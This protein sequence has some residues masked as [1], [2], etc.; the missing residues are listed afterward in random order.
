MNIIN[1]KVNF[2]KGVCQL[3]KGIDLITGDYNSTKMVFDFIDNPT[4]IKVLEM[5]SPDDE[6]TYLG[7][8]QNNEVILVG[9]KEVTTKHENVTY[10]KYVDNNDNV[11]W[12]DP[13]TEKIYDNEWVEQQSVSLDNLTVVTKDVSLFNTE[14]YYI[15]EISLYGDNS[16]LT[17]VSAKIKVKPQQVLEDDEIVT[18]YLPIFDELLNDVSESLNDMDAALDEVDN[19]DFDISKSGVATTVTLTKKDGTTKS[20]QILDATINGETT[21]TIVEGTNI[22][23]TQSGSTMTINNTYDDSEILGNISDLETNKADKSEIPTKTS[24]IT[25]DSGFITKD[26]NNLTNYTTT[27]NMTTAINNAVGTETVNRQSADNN[28]QGQ[29]DAITSASDVVDVV[30][31]YTDLQNYDTSKLTDK[32]LI[33]VMQDSTHNNALSYY[34][35]VS[36]AWS[37][38]G[39]EGPFYT[40]SET[41]TLLNAKQGTI[42]SSHKLSADLVDDTST[43]NK[44]VTASDKLNWS[45]KYDKPSGGIPK[46]DLAS[47]VQTSLGKADSAVQDVSSKEDKTNKATSISSSSTDTQ[48]PSAKCMY[49][50]QEEQNTIMDNL[51]N[52]VDYYKTIG[53]ALPKVSGNGTEITL[54]NTAEA[55][56]ELELNPS[57]LEQATTT[58]KNLLETRLPDT[59]T[60][61]G[62]TITRN[63]DGTFTLNGTSTSFTRFNITSKT[64]KLYFT[65]SELGFVEGETGK[66]SGCPSGGDA[67]AITSTYKF[68]MSGSNGASNID[69]GGDGATITCNSANMGGRYYLAIDCASGITFN[70]LKFKPM[71]EKGSS[72]TEYEPYTG[73]IASPNPS[74]P[75]D[76][77]VITGDNKIYVNTK[78]LAY[79]GWA[80]DFVNRVNDNTRAKLETKDGR[81]CVYYAASTGYGNYDNKYIFK[82]NWKPNTR[83]TIKFDIIGT[84]IQTNI[85]IKYTDGTY[86]YFDYL[87]PNVWVTKT[88]T[89]QINKTIKYVCAVYYD[90]YCYIDLDTFQVE[91]GTTVG[92]YSKGY[93]Q[94]FQLTMGDLEYCKISNYKDRI[95]KNIPSDVDYDATRELGKWYLKK[96]LGKRALDGTENIDEYISENSERYDFPVIPAM[97]TLDNSVA[98]MST[99]F[100]NSNNVSSSVLNKIRFG[101]NNKKLYVYTPVGTYGSTANFKTYLATQYSNN[102]PVIVYYLLET[103]TY[104]LLNNTLQEQLNNIEYA[105]GY[106]DQ[107]NISQ[108]NDDLPFN[109]DASAYKDLSNV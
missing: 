55:P 47:D 84:T 13:E 9:K 7:E 23:I 53:N 37:Y 21:L 91:E 44:F 54:N 1:V 72:I 39:S 12:Y 80:Q 75:Q 88:K 69:E 64:E 73:G 65:L 78:N 68:F 97:A 5:K 33:K 56:M 17:S 100:A 15:F 4:G 86:D 42:D 102:N 16:K 95:F 27:G 79:E 8:I 35:W 60:S 20:E 109:I 18:S 94:V 57:E 45:A 63:L 38:V 11:Y 50:S 31:T 58:G 104:T 89:S 98:G 105:L 107:I 24:D 52:Q 82:T 106:K 36:N 93:Q 62:V 76:I 71:I 6:L 77:H 10:T 83:Y 59:T 74:Y 49:D 66:L 87:T 108:E 22:G 85:L 103:P 43:T 61:N 70:N 90:G 30:A 48:Y 19:L 26:V 81:R 14:G 34:R 67:S 2:T 99:H 29:I 96:N 32:D 41:D 92:N 25:N 28:L 46:T 51:Q 40:K 101:W 3:T